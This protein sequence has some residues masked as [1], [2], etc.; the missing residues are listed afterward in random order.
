MIIDE[1]E[2]EKMSRLK[3]ITGPMRVPFLVLTPACVA[4]GM[5]TALGE[6]YSVSYLEALAVLI[7][8][9]S[10][11]IGVNALNEISDFSSGLDLH[12][13]R[14]PF[15]GG[16]GTLPGHPEL[17]GTTRLTALIS[18]LLVG[19]VG[20]YFTAVRGWQLLPLGVLGLV[21][22]V[23]YSI[24]LVRYPVL[25][26]IAPGLGFGPLMVVGTHLALTGTYSASAFIASLVPFFLVSD[27]L[28]LNQFPD[29][30]ADRAVGRRHLL[31]AADKRT[32]SLVYSLFL[33]LTYVTIAVGVLLDFLPTMTLLGLVTLLLALPAMFGAF[34][35]NENIKR[36]LPFMG[37]NVLI[38]IAT[39][40]LMTAGMLMEL[41]K[42]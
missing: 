41:T 37:M 10:A 42:K 20:T 26:L 18:L 1:K 39:P 31:I 6:Q 17:L 38:N 21:V 14:T 13:D 7:G 35:Y 4:L 8:A 22:V 3:L 15:S 34:R 11:H 32:G 9:V 16:S 5:G 36:L 40:I 29:V 12:T 28:L 24:F 33:V 23:S 19:A 25:C 2:G 30:E 27:L